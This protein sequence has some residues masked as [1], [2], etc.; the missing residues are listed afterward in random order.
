MSGMLKRI[1]HIGVVVDDLDQG[2]RFLEGLGFQHSHDLAVP[3]RGLKATFWKLGEVSIELIQMDDQAANRERTRGEAA[4]I[5]HIA[6]E[7]D[8]IEAT[9]R[10]LAGKGVE[11]TAAPSQV[12]RNVSVWTRPE[13]SDG[14]QFQFMQKG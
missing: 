9:V 1:D 2:R 3:E 10:E 14:Y 7:V 12:G 5:E 4:R 6:V 8:D 13:T 11:T